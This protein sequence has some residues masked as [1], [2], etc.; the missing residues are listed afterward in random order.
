MKLIFL[1]ALYTIDVSSK[2]LSN[3]NGNA[4]AMQRSE[5]KR[6]NFQE[7]L[8]AD[9][10]SSV[11]RQQISPCGTH[12]CKHG[13]CQDKG[14]DYI[15]I[16]DGSGFKGR[17]CDIECFEGRGADY[18]GIMDVTENG[19]TCQRWE[20]QTPHVPYKKC[21]NPDVVP[22]LKTH[23]Y[24]RNRTPWS[25]DRPW[26][27]TIDK[28]KRWEYCKIPYC[29]VEDASGTSNVHC[30]MKHG[31]D[32]TGRRSRTL[33]GRQCQSWSVDSPHKNSNYKPSNSNNLE[34]N[35]CRNPS[36]ANEPWCYTM[37]KNKRWEYCGVP[38]C[39]EQ[40]WID[41]GM[42]WCDKDWKASN[43]KTC[44]D[45]HKNKYCKRG[46]ERGGESHYGSGWQK[47]WVNFEKYASQTEYGPGRSALVCPQCGCGSIWLPDLEPCSNSH[48][49]S[50]QKCL[51]DFLAGCR[52]QHSCETNQD[53][54]GCSSDECEM[55]KE[56]C[57]WPY[58]PCAGTDKGLH[59][60]TNE[61]V[62]GRSFGC[63]KGK[64]WRQCLTKPHIKGSWCYTSIT[65]SDC[66]RDSDCAALDK[67]AWM[68]RCVSQC[69]RA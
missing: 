66:A 68:Q 60:E 46:S 55:V 44:K 3:D 34:S 42:E 47:K 27:Y 20:S 26:C 38:R 23:N 31:E 37:D 10:D 11:R 61:E 59:G 41:V 51:P 13:R 29:S 15:C 53:K 32:Y 64:C 2:S 40:G 57:Y 67:M 25:E 58:Y 19:R 4:P 9:K 28:N 62:Y 36:S 14:S 21:C 17:N 50:I 65:E 5:N 18:L 24:C 16:C 56:T 52:W 1:I 8:P 7:D 63:Y 69:G 48:Q 43:G 12:P 35:Y 33:S 39:I 6:E 30:F 45:Y 22:E 54:N 49:Y